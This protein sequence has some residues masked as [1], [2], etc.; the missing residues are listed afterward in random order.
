MEVCDS[1]LYKGGWSVFGASVGESEK[2]REER[3]RRGVV[4]FTAWKGVLDVDQATMLYLY[5]YII[6][7][8]MLWV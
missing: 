2:G 1:L 3:G 5:K 4:G 7:I 8:S 6:H